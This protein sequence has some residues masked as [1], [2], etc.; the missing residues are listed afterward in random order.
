MICAFIRRKLPLHLMGDLTSRTT[1]RVS[2][3][4]VTCLSCQAEWSRLQALRH[5]LASMETA[6]PDGMLDRF[7]DEVMDLIATPPAAP[8]LPSPGRLH[9]P[10]RKLTF[11]FGFLGVIAI[12]SSL[13]LIRMAWLTHLTLVP[14]TPEDRADLFDMK[15]S[16]ITRDGVILS[17]ARSGEE[18]ASITV[19]K[20]KD[21]IVI[22]WV[23]PIRRTDHAGR[24]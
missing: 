17:D 18:N 6:I 16:M 8:L 2:N 1:A 24:G 4:L 14:N 21:G 22:V 3:H 20:D 11:H 15:P 10:F 12:L 5:H 13:A 7:S 23:A 19:V 9:K